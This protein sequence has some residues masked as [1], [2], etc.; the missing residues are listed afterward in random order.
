MALIH[1]DDLGHGS[2]GQTSAQ[3]RVHAEAASVCL[4]D[5]G[6]AERSPLLVRFAKSDE[7]HEV[8]RLVVD[9]QMLNA[10]RST[11]HATEWGAYGIAILL[12]KLVFGC[13]VTAQ[14]RIGEGFDYWLDDGQNDTLLFGDRRLEVAGLRSAT[15]AEIA[16][17]VEEKLGQT[18]QSDQHRIPAV[19]IIVEFSKP[20]AII[21]ERAA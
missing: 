4:Q 7:G 15:D 20:Q 6:H 2:S 18:K 13:E 21:R 19:A 5:R 9:K 3:G 17:K 11:H 8:Q 12:S 10:Y 1:L 14:G 16:R